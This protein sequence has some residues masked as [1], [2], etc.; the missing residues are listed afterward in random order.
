MPEELNENGEKYRRRSRDHINWKRVALY[1]FGSMPVWGPTTW[2][3]VSYA[4]KVRDQLVEMQAEVPALRREIDNLKLVAGEKHQ[5]QIEIHERRL[6][7]IERWK[8]VIGWDPHE[9]SRNR[10]RVCPEEQ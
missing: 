4:L 2:G 3:G 5:D 9:E 7:R 6:D 10:D 1:V 8:C